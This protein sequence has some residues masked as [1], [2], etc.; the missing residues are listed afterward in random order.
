MASL[1]RMKYCHFSTV[2]HGIY[3]QPCNFMGGAHATKTNYKLA[4][5]LVK[6]KISTKLSKYNITQK[7]IMS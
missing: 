1:P 2:T 5:Q 7:A 3:V 6:R 4:H